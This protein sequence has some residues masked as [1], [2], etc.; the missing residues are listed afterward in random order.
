M[1]T[2][3]T[4]HPNGLNYYPLLHFKQEVALVVALVNT[5]TFYDHIHFSWISWVSC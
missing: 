3:H 2:L 5:Q 4:K 1:N